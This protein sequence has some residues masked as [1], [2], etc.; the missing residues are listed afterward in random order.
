MKLQGEKTQEFFDR[1]KKVIPYGVNSNF[2]YWGDE[3]TIVINRGE[4][5]YVWDM[6]GKRYIDYRLGFGPVILGH[7]Y[8]EVVTSVQEALQGGNIFAWT[9]PYEISVAERITR[10][11]NV[12]KVRLTNTGTEATMHALRIARAHTGREKFIKFE[13][14][15]H[16]MA[17]YFMFSTASSYRGGLGSRRSPIPL[18]NTSGIP[19]AINHYVLTVL[20]NDFEGLERKVKDNW[21]DLAAIIVEPMLGNTASIMPQPG[22]LEKIRELCDQYGIV[23]IFDE[24]KTGFR[25]AK[26]GAQEYFG[27][28][29][30]LAT[31]A[32]SMGNGFPIA[33]IAGKEDVMM[34]IEPGAMAHGGTYSG[35]VVGAAAA[36]AT[37]EILE[38]QPILETINERGKAL[39]AGIGDVL[40]EAGLPHVVTGV[41]SMFGIFLGSDEEPHDFRDYLAGDGELYEE[42][43]IGLNR[44]GIQPDADGREPWFLCYALSEEDVAETLNAFNDAVKEAKH[45]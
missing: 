16:G 26:G 24:V 11:C 1:G 2:R 31:Y 15:Y 17:D 18:A 37:L 22:F 27:V 19:K 34:T 35:N 40:T 45:K 20:Y 13:G 42:I 41:P 44:R 28:Q 7:A 32:K 4:G 14:Q 23:M 9:T 25:I 36:E 3:D 8:P 21:G 5:A 29:A 38:N 39:M 30:D 33:A 10:M 6:D 43:S 12:D